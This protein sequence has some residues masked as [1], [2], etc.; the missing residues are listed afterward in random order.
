ML[1]RLV[2][3][4][5]LQST[6]AFCSGIYISNK[7]NE[8]HPELLLSRI[9]KTKMNKTRDLES[10]INI[11]SFMDNPTNINNWIRLNKG[12][13]TTKLSYE[14]WLET[15]NKSK[16]LFLEKS[17][18]GIISLAKEDIVKKICKTDNPKKAIEEILQIYG[19]TIEAKYK[20]DEYIDKYIAENKWISYSDI[21]L[22]KNIHIENSSSAIINMLIISILT[23]PLD[24]TEVINE[25]LSHSKTNKV[26]ILKEYFDKLTIQEKEY[27]IE[28]VIMYGLEELYRTNQQK[29]FYDKIKEQLMSNSLIGVKMKNYVDSFIFIL[30]KLPMDKTSK[31]VRSF[32]M[33]KHDETL[34]IKSII[35]EF[36][37]V[38]IKIAQYYSE[39]PTIPEYYKNILRNFKEENVKMSY[40]DIANK[41]NSE[42]NCSLGKVIGI[43]SVK[44]VHLMKHNEN[45]SILGFTKA[46]IETDTQIILDIL[47]KIPEYAK[48]ANDF[49][50]IISEKLIL[51]NEYNAFNKLASIDRFR[52]S[53]CFIFPEILDVS[54]FT[55]QR[56]FIEGNTIGKLHQTNAI[57]DKL[58]SKIKKLHILT[59]EAAFYDKL[60]FSDLHFGNIIYNQNCDKLVIIDAG[61]STKVPEEDLTLFI[62]LMVDLVSKNNYM[63]KIFIDKLNEHTKSNFNY[64]LQEY[65]KAYQMPINEAILYIMTFLE[66][67]GYNLPVGFTVT[68]KMLEIIRSQI[69]YLG[70]NEDYFVETLKNIIKTKITYSDYMKVIYSY[71]LNLGK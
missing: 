68:A 6:I 47:K 71:T 19:H 38:G 39:Y 20:I 15:I 4:R 8:K 37:I 49:K 28:S 34:L 56:E 18:F 53:D 22:L 33:N 21:N 13:K 11:I 57:T 1:K 55:I 45:T 35:N 51:F 16:I 3:N 62:W 36:G 65:R 27:V 12:N 54:I 30:S 31:I 50:K 23:C 61:Q 60:I 29:I 2:K 14:Q 66:K 32:L 9:F 24:I 10:Q 17:F 70:L 59:I 48:M 44:Q 41:I 43:G 25:L 69:L 64:D 63:H 42:D 58:L 46:N 7:F 67:V 52:N 40:F 26:E 5:V